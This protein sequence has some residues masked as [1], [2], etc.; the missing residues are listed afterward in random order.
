MDGSSSCQQI[1]RENI[2]RR[3]LTDHE[4]VGPRQEAAQLDRLRGGHAGANADGQRRKSADVEGEVNHQ[5]AGE[6]KCP[7]VRTSPSTL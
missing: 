2:E 7:A 3:H 4:E 5:S 6:S 1:H